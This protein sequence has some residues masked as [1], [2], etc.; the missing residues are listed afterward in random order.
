MSFDVVEGPRGP[1]LEGYVFNDYIAGADRILVAVERVSPSGEAVGCAMIWVVGI[2]QPRDRAYFA[3]SV[4]DA[5]AKY[6]VRV[7]SFTG[8]GSG[9]P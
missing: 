8:A 9:G 2:V 5:T 7:L 6:R 3:A 4:P 1:Q